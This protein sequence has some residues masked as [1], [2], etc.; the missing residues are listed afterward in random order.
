MMFYLC[1]GQEVAFVAFRFGVL[2]FIKIH[3][4]LHFGSHT[5]FV[6]RG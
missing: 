5:P 6:F 4:A 3:L 1:E 2:A